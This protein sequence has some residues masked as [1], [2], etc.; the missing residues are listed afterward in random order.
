M[1][2][3]AGYLPRPRR[4]LD[5]SRYA[6]ANCGPVSTSLGMDWSTGGKVHPS[7]AAV[8]DAMGGTWSGPGDATNLGDNARAWA[9]YRDDARE[10]GLRLGSYTRRLMDPWSE[11]IDALDA[12]YG[13]VL[14]VS[15]PTITARAPTLSGDPAFKGLHVIFLAAIRRRKG[16]VQLLSFD[17]LYDGRRAGI[18][19]G[20]QWVPAWVLKEAAEEKVRRS[21]VSGG[22]AAGQAKERADGTAV[23]AVIGRSTAIA[24]PDPKPAPTPLTCEERIEVAVAAAEASLRDVLAGEIDAMADRIKALELALGGARTALISAGDAVD[25]ALA[26]IDEVMP[27]APDDGSAP[28]DGVGAER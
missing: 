16:N 7:P 21:L 2:I 17:G 25:D 11:V 22:M 8:R 4:Q 6:S 23:F 18:P 24:K 15:Y 14:Q 27:A 28:D 10:K 20:A 9:T 5:G 3:P 1:T 13:V 19:K 12:G 26:D